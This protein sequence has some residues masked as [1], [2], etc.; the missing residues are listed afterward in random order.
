MLRETF[1]CLPPFALILSLQSGHVQHHKQLSFGSA[2]PLVN[3]AQSLIRPSS[4]RVGPDYSEERMNFKTKRTGEKG[5][6]DGFYP[7][8]PLTNVLGT[9][10]LSCLV[11]AGK[12]E[13]QK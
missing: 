3:S 6:G 10:H 5:Y 2:R 13:R 4:L 9:A 12:L 7:E 1:R 8:M 11:S